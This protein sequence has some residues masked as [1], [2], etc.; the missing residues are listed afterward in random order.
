MCKIIFR[1]VN[2][3]FILFLLTSF[4]GCDFITG[5]KPIYKAAYKGNLKKVKKIIESDP[6]QIN[7][8]DFGGQTPLYLASVEGHTEIVEFLLDHNADIELGNDLNER[9]L[10][11]AAK[12]GHYDIVKAL[13]VHGATVNCKNKYG[14]IPL[15]WAAVWSNKEMV[16]LLL[17]YGADIFAKDKYNETPLH[18]AA[19]G[20]NKQ[21][22]DVLLSHG[23]DIFAK[24]SSNQTPREVALKHGFEK[25]VVCQ[26][27]ICGYNGFSLILASVVVNC[28]STPFCNSFLSTFHE[29]HSLFNRSML[30]ILRSRHWRLNALNSISAMFSQLPCLGV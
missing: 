2:L 13:L 10:E 8:Q 26:Y 4:I 25:L 19:S 27:C 14:Q 7:I 15:H 28:Q 17:S 11:K 16:G 5:E 12:F 21:V 3:C 20:D 1:T 23:A 9:P 18:W 22:V 30:S 6:A 24:N 29:R